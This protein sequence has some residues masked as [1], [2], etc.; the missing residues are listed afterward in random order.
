MIQ[1]SNHAHAFRDLLALALATVFPTLITLV[2][3]QWLHDSESSAQQIAFGLGKL[4]QFVFPVTFI[5]FFYREKLPWI[6]RLSTSAPIPL[7]IEKTLLPTRSFPILVGIAFGIAISIAMWAIFFGVIPASIAANLEIQVT[8]KITSMGLQKFSHFLLL[9]VFYVVCHSFMEEYY[10]RW[11][12][13]DLWR[14]YL[15]MAAANFL[16]SVGFMAHHIIVLA[17]YFGWDSPLTYLFSCCV[18]IGGSFWAWLYGQEN[19]LRSAWISH[20]IVDAAIFGL[21]MWLM[22]RFT[23]P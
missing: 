6:T 18:G 22:F 19:R 8:Q 21:G 3:F 5:W 1:R 17:F 7:D 16:S 15:T 2:Y 11:F 12:V 10:W 14:R 23:K 9:A 20:A 4:L 13:F